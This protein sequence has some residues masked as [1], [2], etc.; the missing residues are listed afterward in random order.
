MEKAVIPPL[1]L[2]KNDTS[3]ENLSSII[4]YVRQN[5]RKNNSHK[6]QKNYLVFIPHVTTPCSKSQS[7]LYEISAHHHKIK[8]I[9]RENHPSYR[10]VI[11]DA[12]KGG[13]N[14]LHFMVPKQF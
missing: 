5:S 10:T 4:V 3:P 13:G 8:V 12:D 2:H 7:I 14:R 11:L 1:N 6:I 9:S